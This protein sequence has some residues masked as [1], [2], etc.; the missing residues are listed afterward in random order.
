M[1]EVTAYDALVNLVGLIE[2]Q[3]GYADTLPHSDEFRAGWRAACNDLQH[4]ALMDEAKTVLE[5]AGWTRPH[6]AWKRPTGGVP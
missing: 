5:E 4:H 2:A 6:R 1:A 3:Y